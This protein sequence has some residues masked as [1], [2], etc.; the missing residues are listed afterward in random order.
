MNVYIV[1]VCTKANTKIK[2]QKNG[3]EIPNIYAT[4]SS[5]GLKPRSQMPLRT[6]YERRT[7]DFQTMEIWKDNGKT[8][9]FVR[10][11]RSYEP[12]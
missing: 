2:K 3:I 10:N 6:A 1:Q 12:L 11:Y 8:G 7:N 9:R 4:Y 5:L